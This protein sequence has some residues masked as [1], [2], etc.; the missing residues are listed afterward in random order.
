VNGDSSGS[1]VAEEGSVSIGEA[2]CRR[3][4]VFPEGGRAAIM[5][6]D[7]GER[8]ISGQQAPNRVLVGSR[9]DKN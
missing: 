4:H 2:A 7:S 5:E 9:P 3:P 8:L 1:A 6:R